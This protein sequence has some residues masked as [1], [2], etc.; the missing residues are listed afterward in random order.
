MLL[1]NCNGVRIGDLTIW[2]PVALAPMVGLSHS[3]LR[4]LVQELGGVGL[5][6]TEMLAAKRLPSDNPKIS[7]MLVRTN[8]EQPLMY[9]LVT[10][11]VDHVPAAL[12]KIHRLGAAGVDLNLGCP[13]PIQK[14]QGAGSALAFNRDTLR[15]VLRC[16]RTHTGLPL[17]VKI[18]LGTK[19]D[20]DSLSETCKFYEGEGVDL[21]TVHGRLVGEKFCRKPRWSPIAAAKK[22]V[23][24]PVFANG[25]IFSAGDAQKCLEQSGAD[26]IMIGRAAVEKPWLCAQISGLLFG[27]KYSR[28]CINKKDIFYAFFD[29]LETRFSEEKR[30]VRLKHF[31]RYYAASFK[32]GHH[33]TSSVLRSETMTE[34][35]KRSEEFFNKT[36]HHE[37]LLENEE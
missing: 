1:E 14:R 10:G 36:A 12:E 33:L 30:L 17:S 15:A 5:L 7:P 11:S 21:I 29:L 9:Q 35:K 13:A 26:G 6:Y 23:D 37:L 19:V 4:S 31:S 8:Q 27:E 32:F 25:G 16:I 18:R 28:E 20:D 2:P 24:I 34:A 22:A 3:A